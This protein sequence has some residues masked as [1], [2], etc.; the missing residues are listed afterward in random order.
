MPNGDARLNWNAL[1]IT[2]LFQYLRSPKSNLII[3]EMRS[4]ITRWVRNAVRRGDMR[5]SCKILV[6]KLGRMRPLRELNV[7]EIK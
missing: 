1:E 3:G 6:G 7:N 4:R 2:G 5:N